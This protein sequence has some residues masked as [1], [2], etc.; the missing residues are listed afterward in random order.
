MEHMK[1]CEKP[2]ASLPK[3]RNTV[4]QLLMSASI[5]A[6][7]DNDFACHFLASGT[8]RAS[9]KLRHRSCADHCDYG[10]QCTSSIIFLFNPSIACR[11]SSVTGSVPVQL[12]P[13]GPLAISMPELVQVCSEKC[14]QWV[15]HPAVIRNS[16]SVHWIGYPFDGCPANG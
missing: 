11:L 13:G 12:Y 16:K 1:L 2:W 4:R 7:T 6:L 14:D 15:I 8:S 3:L 5:L 9:W 10:P